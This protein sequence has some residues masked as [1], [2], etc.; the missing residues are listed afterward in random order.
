MGLSQTSAD[1]YRVVITLFIVMPDFNPNNSQIY[2]KWGLGVPEKTKKKL[3][4]SKSLFEA[5]IVMIVA[6][7]FR[8][9]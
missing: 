3:I 1:L 5:W 2:F 7:M 6:P 4:I 9:L 8:Q